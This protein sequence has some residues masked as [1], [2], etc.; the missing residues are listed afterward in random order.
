M[1]RMWDN[2][3]FPLINELKP[4]YIVEVGAERGTNTKSMLE[5]CA[6][7]DARLTTIDPFPIFDVDALKEEYGDKFDMIE[8]LSLNVLNSIKDYDLII[9]DGDHNWYTVYNELK[10]IEMNFIQDTFP[11]VIFHDVSWPYARRDIYYNPNDIPEDYLNPHKKRGMY[12][13][14]SKL[15]EEGG[16]NASIDNATEEN[17]PRNGVLTGIEDFLKE[18]DLNLTFKILNAFHGLGLM[19]IPSEET[20]KIIHDIIWNSNITGVMDEYYLKQTINLQDRIMKLNKDINMKNQEIE[21][22]KNENKK[23][24]AKNKKLNKKQK[25]LLSSKSWKMTKPLRRFRNK[26]L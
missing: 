19:Y 5:Y 1:N 17:T 11:F 3:V 16:L 4:K 6:K 24:K 9:L 14:E 23:L 21:K 22:I 7:N 25:E 10:S 18:T 8:D 13:G 26:L 2:L 15:R 12:P 20:D